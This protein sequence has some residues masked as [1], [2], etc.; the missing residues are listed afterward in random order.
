MQK[1]LP[2][3]IF[4]LLALPVYSS[5]NSYASSRMNF[6]NQQLHVQ[7]IN[8]SGNL[9]VTVPENF[10]VYN[11]T[12]GATNASG[13]V[14]WSVGGTVNYTIQ[15]PTT[16]VE[17]TLYFS[18][19]TAD[20]TFFDKFT[21][22]CIPDGKVVDYKAEY[23]H[24]DANYLD[25]N[26]ISND[27]TTIFNLI[28]VFN[29][30]N[31]LEP[32]EDALNA[33][34]NCLFPNMPVRTYGLVEV[35]R[36]SNNIN[37]NFSWDTIEGGYWFRIGV[38]S[39]D[40]LEKPVGYKYNV[41]CGS[42][43][44]NFNHHRVVASFT[45]TSLEIRSKNP[46]NITVTNSSDRLT[47]TIQNIEKYST[48]N[49]IFKWSLNNLTKYEEFNTLNPN[50]TI[51]FDLF[52]EGS[53]TVNFEAD[54]VPS[55]FANSRNP[56]VYTQIRNDS[57]NFDARS[58]QIVNLAVELLRVINQTASDTRASQQKNFRAELSD[59]GAIVGNQVYRARLNIYDFEGKPVNAS[60]T[61]RILIYDPL[62]NF[63]VNST[64][65]F[66]E[67]GVYTYNYTTSQSQTTGIYETI[68]EV[69]VS[70][71]VV[72]PD[73]FWQLAN[74]P[75]QVKINNIADSTVPTITANVLIQN[76]GS[77]DSEYQYEYCIVENET[78]QCGGDDDVDFGSAAKLI[79]AGDTFNPLLTLNVPSPGDYYFKMIVYFGTDASGAT[80]KFTAV[81]APVEIGTSG[82]AG[83]GRNEFDINFKS[84]VSLT[85]SLLVSEGDIKT[86]TF[87]GY[88]EHTLV[89]DTIG[90]NSMV[91]KIRSAPITITLSIGETNNVDLNGD[92]FADISI[93][94]NA[95]TNGKADLTIKKL[96]GSALIP[97][98]SCLEDWVC[99]DFSQCY[100]DSRQIRTCIDRNECGT[101]YDKPAD[102]MSCFYTQQQAQPLV[103][104]SGLTNYLSSTQ[105]EIRLFAYI[106]I[107]TSIISTIFI[108]FSYS[109]RRP[110][111]AR[112]KEWYRIFA[113][114]GKTRVNEL[115]LREE[116]TERMIAMLDH[117]YNQGSI[118]E[119]TRNR[120]KAQLQKRL[121]R[122]RKK[123][124]S[125]KAS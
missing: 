54:F 37:G 40:I 120:N 76:E 108:V 72:K 79:K 45:N 63:I 31:F 90:K 39:Q 7:T 98:R 51:K 32:N 21:F 1:I 107:F 96:A 73:D 12:G 85:S 77:A 34:I 67:T 62:R 33:T 29:I 42:L 122:I 64:M 8:F 3:V 88:V 104:F 83:G 112:Y 13:V 65:T 114:D 118:D 48:K 86:I 9:S 97:K 43:N 4:I 59:F 15:G 44:Y 47:Y 11:F 46:F 95:I 18:N 106:V 36:G 61:P 91:I 22:V 113:F 10:T 81:P 56:T 80:Q 74:S 16:C 111:N 121:K 35:T 119:V 14:N 125:L 25:E 2:V 71:V 78:N 57:Y 28:R 84:V 55:W 23:G 41:T 26:F 103:D 87:D 75:A 24:G 49:I 116:K 105:D 20:G 27:S 38:L 109:R 58:P 52:L 117:A 5:V 6:Y 69:S 110:K 102:R 53:G 30:G 50:D 115:E 99:T 68:V 93:T 100:P 17:G 94:L 70:D 66:S 92:T 60:S 89:M 101:L 19:I 82:G 124:A 123:I